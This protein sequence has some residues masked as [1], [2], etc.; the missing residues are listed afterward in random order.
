MSKNKLNLYKKISLFLL[1]GFPVQIFSQSGT[2]F[3][4]KIIR[5]DVGSCPMLE[6]Y[7][8]TKDYR[9]YNYFLTTKIKSGKKFAWR[10][11]IGHNK[12]KAI[13]PRDS[14]YYRGFILLPSFGIEW[15]NFPRKDRFNFYIGCEAGHNWYHHS[16]YK[17]GYIN[18]K[19]NYYVFVFRGVLGIDFRIYKQIRF[20]FEVAMGPSYQFETYYRKYYSNNSVYYSKD[21]NFYWDFYKSMLF[22]IGYDL[23]YNRSHKK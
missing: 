22:G 21:E 7:T 23:G 3:K 15:N 14:G 11:G 5:I 6:G 18:R 17:P 2:S 10:A 1:F 16:S 9:N 20:S 19:T 8:F 4:E 12:W 13:E